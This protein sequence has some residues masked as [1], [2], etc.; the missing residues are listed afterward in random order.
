LPAGVPP[1]TLRF[2]TP[3]PTPSPPDEPPTRPRR[4]AQP[5]SLAP[6]GGARFFP[7]SAARGAGAPVT[8]PP[9]DRASARSRGSS[10]SRVGA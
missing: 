7:P 4:L 3:S 6:A 5:G 10:E 9:R 8:L 1:L 2:T